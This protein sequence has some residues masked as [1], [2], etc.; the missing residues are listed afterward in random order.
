LIIFR[1]TGMSSCHGST[2]AGAL[3][4]C[5]REHASSRGACTLWLRRLDVSAWAWMRE[6]QW[7]CSTWLCWRLGLES[8]GRNLFRSVELFPLCFIQV[9]SRQSE[10]VYGPSSLRSVACWSFLCTLCRVPLCSSVAVMQ[11]SL[12]TGMFFLP[13]DL[14]QPLAR[15]E[16]MLVTAG[17]ASGVI[18]CSFSQHR[19]QTER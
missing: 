7:C 3:H 12:C 19:P 9:T 16:S 8:S 13:L 10:P 2:R 15:L 5:S 1:S 4:P 18:L 11:A 17:A 6:F 14:R